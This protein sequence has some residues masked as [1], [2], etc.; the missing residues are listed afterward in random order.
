M[1]SCELTCYD[2]V[3]ANRL[4][5]EF[6]KEGYNSDISKRQ[7]YIA[8]L[9]STEIEAQSQYIVRIGGI[10]DTEKGLGSRFKELYYRIM[11]DNPHLS[12]PL[13]WE[14]I[15]TVYDCFTPDELPKKNK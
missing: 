12:F 5:K 7:G 2:E 4:A 1:Y 6:G 3:T 8:G 10:D 9:V 11:R 13:D 15:P 14:I